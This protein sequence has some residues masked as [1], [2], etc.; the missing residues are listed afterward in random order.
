MQGAEESSKAAIVM[1]Y[2]L[3]KIEFYVHKKE[4]CTIFKD[5]EYYRIRITRNK[6]YKSQNK[7]MSR[8][9]VR[10]K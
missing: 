1:M 4:W 3:R 7:N 8:K 10:C 9:V 2:T 5:K 6:K